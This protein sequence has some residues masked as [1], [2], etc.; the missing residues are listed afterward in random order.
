MSRTVKVC[1][2]LLVLLALPLARAFAFLTDSGVH[3]PPN[4]YGFVP[5]ARGGSYTDSTY[6]TS[7]RRITDARNTPDAARGSGMLT[8]IT[9]EYST[10]SPFNSNSTRLLLQHYSYFALYD[11]NG[12]FVRNLPFEI[13]SSS[14][15]RW[16]RSNPNVLYYVTGNQLK[17][18]EASTGAVSMVRAFTEYSAVRGA[19]ES[20]I[21]FDGNHLVLVGSG[22]YVFVYEISTNT[23]GSVLD[24]GG[25]AFDSL[26]ITP[27]DNVTVTWAQ[28]GTSRFNGIELFNRNMGFLRQVT[29]AGGHMDVTRDTNG[30]E[31]LLWANAAD[32]LPICDNGVVKVRLSDGRQT[33]L[34]SLAW[35]IA[36]HVSGPDSGGWAFV[37]TYN[38]SDPSP[39]SGSWTP[40]VNEVL[41]IRLDGSQVRRLLHHRSRPFDSYWYTP[42]VASNRAGTR[43]VFSSNYGQQ[44]ISGASTEYTDVYMVDVPGGSAPAPT[45]TP[46]PTPA[47][48]PAPTP[49]PTPA[50]A[51]GQ[52]RYEENSSAVTLTGTWSVNTLA[53]H[54]GGRAVLGLEPGARATLTFSGTS[55]SWI[56]YRDEWSGIARVYL[57]GVLKGTVDTYASPAQSQATLYTANGLANGNHTLAVEVTGTRSSASASNWVWVDAFLVNG[58]GAVGVATPRSPSGS[59]ATAT[60]TYT[61]SAASGAAEYRLAVQQTASGTSVL[62]QWFSAASVCSGST[63]SVTPSTTLSSEAHRFWIQARNGSLTG[64]WSAGMSFTVSTS[65]PGPAPGPAPGV[66]SPISPTGTV[67]TTRPT[68]TWSTVAGATA[69]RLAVQVKATGAS[70]HD[71]WHTASTVCTGGTCSVT[72]AASLGS[73]AHRFWVQA[74]NGTVAGGWSAGR[75]FTVSASAPSGVPTLLSPQATIS[76][77]SPPFR[78]T[79]VSGATEYRLAVQYTANGSSVHD[80]WHPA[81][82]CSGGTCSVQLPSALAAGAHRWWVQTRNGSAVGGWSAGMSFAVVGP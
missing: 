36:I 4:Y 56:G 26:Y 64:G 74:R 80:Q 79:S 11:G 52:G 38:A 22:R 50:P 71:Q 44:A 1:L 8:F 39:S 58:G 12:T 15:P 25:R 23:K 7:I 81:S 55:V 62:D 63:C 14:E 20:D 34:L 49:T 10:M 72:P 75:D 37:E 46:T 33:C 68:Y 5:P 77:T 48:T 69:Y 17:S 35:G 73:G 54:S 30:D 59:V 53:L 21:C 6:G 16:S 60:P 40:W 29:R 45:P 24:T 18:Y 57:D 47:P 13:S 19:G 65:G 61:W 78:W 3:T 66:P 2:V 51:P 42:R 70:A 76:T 31:V 27:N 82:A 67:A 32:P 9:N 41:Q 43:L 28:S